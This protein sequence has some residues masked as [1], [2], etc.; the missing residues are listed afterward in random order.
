MAELIDASS[1]RVL[2][3]AGAVEQIRIAGVPGGFAMVVRYGMSEKI[4]RAQRGHA[5]VFKSLDAAARFARK[6]GFS[7]CVL[8]LSSGY[9]NEHK[10]NGSEE[11][12][13]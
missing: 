3:E 2:A 5:R 9:G 13:A 6:L 11:I 10:M 7:Q 1:L 8:D 4:L 12:L